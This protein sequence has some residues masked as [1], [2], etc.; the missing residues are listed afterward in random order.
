MLTP[1]WTRNVLLPGFFFD[2]KF[3]YENSISKFNK[4]ERAESR[5]RDGS[6]GLVPAAGVAR[7]TERGRRV[8]S[9]FVEFVLER[10]RIAT[11]SWSTT[12][13]VGMP[14]RTLGDREKNTSRYLLAVSWVRDCTVRP[15]RE[16]CARDSSTLGPHRL[17]LCWS[18]GSPIW[19][20]SRLRRRRKD[21]RWHP[22]LSR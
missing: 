21:R 17:E 12:E 8:V 22:R 9:I 18:R 19:S 14:A 11:A 13:P 7:T 1:Q 15:A 16:Q 10:P 4:K 6:H 5:E 20:L 3:F 2:G